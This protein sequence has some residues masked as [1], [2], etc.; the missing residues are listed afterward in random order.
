M[1]VSQAQA[2]CGEKTISKEG[3]AHARSKLFPTFDRVLHNPIIKA[4]HDRMA[5]ERKQKK[6]VIEA[7]E[8]KL[9]MICSGVLKSGKSFD[10]KLCP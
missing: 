2:F 6:A 7:C 1:W 5:A 4:S 8:R 9:V 3:S 10:P